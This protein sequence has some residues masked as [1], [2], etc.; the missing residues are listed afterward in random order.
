MLV[1]FVGVGQTQQGLQLAAQ[2]G[3]GVA[4]NARVSDIQTNGCFILTL[5]SHQDLLCSYDYNK[6]YL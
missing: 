4:G 2:K 6:V 5:Y 3:H 1:A